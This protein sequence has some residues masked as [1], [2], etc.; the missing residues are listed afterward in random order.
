MEVVGDAL[1]VLT[2]C[3]DGIGKLI[4]CLPKEQLRYCDLIPTKCTTSEVMLW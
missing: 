3:H 1:K 4:A 2:S